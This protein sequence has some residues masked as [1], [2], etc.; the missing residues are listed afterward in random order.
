MGESHFMRILSDI[1]PGAD[2]DKVRLV[3]C[4]GKV[5]YDLI[6]AR[7]AAGDKN[8]HRAHRTALSLPHEPLAVRLARMTNLEEVVWCA[9]RAAQHG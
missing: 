4:S 1:N 2:K 6:E 8:T 7:D 5:A 9:G 3:L